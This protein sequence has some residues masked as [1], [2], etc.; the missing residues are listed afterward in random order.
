L[1]ILNYPIGAYDYVK[2][3][4]V[5]ILKKDVEGLEKDRTILFKDD[6]VQTGALV[7]GVGW[8]FTPIID[9]R[10]KEMHAEL[11]IYSSEFSRTQ[12]ELWGKIDSRRLT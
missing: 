1:A 11:G 5:R 9:L 6:S 2:S 3:G 7:C 4:R 8:K 10:P 12:R